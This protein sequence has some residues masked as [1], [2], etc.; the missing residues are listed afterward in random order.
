[1]VGYYVLLSKLYAD[2]GKWDEV[3]RLRW[4]MRERGLSVDP[5]CS[6]VEVKGKV[7]AFLS[8]D[9]THP[10]KKE[11]D[12]V[13]EG[14][15]E[16]MKGETVKAASAKAEIFCGHSERQAVAFGLI[17]TAPGTPIWVT[18][19]LYM[20]RG[21]HDTIK[22]ISSIVRRDISVRDAQELHSFKDGLCSCGDEGYWGSKS[23]N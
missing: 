14:L 2:S 17:S 11:I 18:K 7:H 23:D 3:A 9:E 22:F 4:T 8:G 20:C 12:A 10:R 1:M 15:R 19:N 13:M 16:R 6:W 21:C 5:G